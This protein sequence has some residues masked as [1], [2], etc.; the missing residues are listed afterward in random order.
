MNDE[1]IDLWNIFF[2]RLGEFEI[3]I[4]RN[5]AIHVNSK[6][7]REEGMVLVQ[8]YFREVRPFIITQISDEDNLRELDQQMQ[9]LLELTQQ[10]SSKDFYKKALKLSKQHIKK[11][12][13]QREIELSKRSIIK[14]EEKKSEFSGL[15]KSIYVTLGEL[16]PT[17]ALS[18]HQ[19]LL[20]LKD[21]R[22][23]S[24]RGTAN[25]LREVLRETLDHLAPDKEVM[26]QPG[27]VLEKDQTKPTMKQKARFILR[28]RGLSLTASKVP[29]QSI[30]VI[31]ELIASL[32]RSIYDRSSISSHVSLGITEVIKI[33]NYINS[34]LAELLSIHTK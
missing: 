7:L 32:A 30:G 1:S 20:D 2:N 11:I 5:R 23:L 25:E 16:V 14:V 27:F 29:E 31:E 33:K 12:S 13:I 18:Y 17:A 10:R 34:V 24:F 4:N 19:A 9:R 3:K 28:S 15:E 6:S 8:S 22:R 26:E 21:S